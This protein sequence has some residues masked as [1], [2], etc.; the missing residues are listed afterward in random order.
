MQEEVEAAR[1]RCDAAE[2]ASA[3]AAKEKAAV[4]AA[5]E[6][7]RSEQSQQRG[8]EE[9]SST[10][11]EALA[12]SEALCSKLRKEAEV[13]ALRGTKAEEEVVASE[14]HLLLSPH[15]PST[16]TELV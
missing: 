16:N 9:D 15:R 1:K 3:G 11:S 7:P 6:A 13:S 5:L 12:S 4:E 14:Q 8:E 2:A 10:A